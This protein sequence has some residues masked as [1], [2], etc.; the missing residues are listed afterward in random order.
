[1]AR[2]ALVL[3]LPSALSYSLAQ[4]N[5]FDMMRILKSLGGGMP[6]PDFRASEDHEVKAVINELREAKKAKARF[7]P[8][9][10]RPWLCQNVAY[11]S[12]DK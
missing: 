8:K 3:A 11:C 9:F 4:S 7:N 6:N 2:E 1:M 5:T 10:P 12:F